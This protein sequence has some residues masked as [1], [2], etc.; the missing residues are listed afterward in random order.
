MPYIVIR[1]TEELSAAQKQTIKAELGEKISVIPGKGERGLMI[2]FVTGCSI[3]LSGSDEPATY[4]QVLVNNIQPPEPLKAFSAELVRVLAK[5]QKVAPD[6][7]YVLHQSVVDWHVG[8][9]FAGE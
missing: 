9:M 3:Y 7:V 1:T 5:V 6:R 4:A 8:S 2:E